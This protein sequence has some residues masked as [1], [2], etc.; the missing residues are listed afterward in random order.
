MVKKQKDKN[1]TGLLLFPTITLIIGAFIFSILVL[2]EIVGIIFYSKLEDTTILARRI[3]III[4]AVIPLLL[5]I[6]S[7]NKEFKYKK[8]FSLLATITMWTFSISIMFIVSAFYTLS[9]LAIVILILIP[10]FWTWYF[11]ASK[12]VKDTFTN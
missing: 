3:F 9:D 2:L 11:K 7:I 4:F 12:Q 8:S 1:I 6:N 10:I 5:A